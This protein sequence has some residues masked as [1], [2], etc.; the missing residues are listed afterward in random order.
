MKKMNRYP[1][2]QNAEIKFNILADCQIALKIDILFNRASDVNLSGMVIDEDWKW[3]TN[4]RKIK[5]YTLFKLQ[6]LGVSQ[7]GEVFLW[8]T[9]IRPVSE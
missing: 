4:T 5:Y 9:F 2:R 3:F 6:L 1:K 7:E 8:T